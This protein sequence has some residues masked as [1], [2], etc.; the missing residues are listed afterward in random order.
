MKEIADI[1]IHNL[2]EKQKLTDTT[3]YNISLF[4]HLTKNAKHQEKL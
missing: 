4:Y 2:A 3:Q 1:F